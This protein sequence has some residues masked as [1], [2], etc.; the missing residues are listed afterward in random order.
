MESGVFIALC[1]VSEMCFGI[2]DCDGAHC[3]SDDIL[4]KIGKV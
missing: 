2:F 1:E 4:N 3:Y